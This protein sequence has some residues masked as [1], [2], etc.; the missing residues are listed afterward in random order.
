MRAILSVVI[1]ISSAMVG[2]SLARRLSGRVKT[3]KDFITLFEKCQIRIRYENASLCDAFSD[4]AVDYCFNSQEEF[5]TQWSRFIEETGRSLNHEDNRILSDFACDLGSFDTDSQLT[6]ISLY[7]ELLRN[8][9]SA[10]EQ[11]QNQKNRMY[12]VLPISIGIVIA[13]LLI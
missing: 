6:H 9:L 5:K 12:L 13:I 4:N 10:A 3:L 7:L 2:Y 1:V 8:N 11:E